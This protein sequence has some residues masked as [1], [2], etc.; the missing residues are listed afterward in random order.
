[1]GALDKAKRFYLKLLNELRED[2]RDFGALHNNLVE[3][4]RK[5]GYFDSAEIH[6]RRALGVYAE[7]VTIFHPYRAIVHS[8]SGSLYQSCDLSKKALEHYRCALLILKKYTRFYPRQFLS[9]IYHCMG[10][11]YQH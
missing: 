3:I 2:Y 10:V 9:T 8:N 5:Q 11:V 4:L 6:F 7:T 1:M